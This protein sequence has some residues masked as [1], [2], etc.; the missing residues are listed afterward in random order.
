[1]D[2]KVSGDA[3][4]LYDTSGSGNDGTTSYGAN[5][6]GM[7]CTVSGKFGTGCSFDGVD[8]YLNCGNSSNLDISSIT[9]SAWIKIGSSL[10]PN[11]GTVIAKGN[12]AD[13]DH[14]WLSYQTAGNFRFEYGNETTRVSASYNIIPSLNTWYHVAATYTSGSGYVYINGARGGQQTGLTGN[15]GINT[16]FLTIGKCSYA[17][18]HYWNGFIDDIRLFNEAMPTSQIR[19]Q[20]YS[21]LN[22]LFI[23]GAISTNDYVEGIKSSELSVR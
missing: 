17:S 15:L 9:V 18:S 4:K 2:E 10:P 5:L 11:W 7:D 23:N 16:Y 13:N 14:F 6:T 20:Y 3:K 8:D 22:K 1:M 19:E 12:Q 21:G